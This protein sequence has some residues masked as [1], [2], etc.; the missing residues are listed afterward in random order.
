LKINYEAEG[1]TGKLKRMTKEIKG[2]SR[3]VEGTR[4]E[5][6]STMTTRNLEIIGAGSR[7]SSYAAQL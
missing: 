1:M 5:I 2:M 4:T 6:E 3:E 7:S